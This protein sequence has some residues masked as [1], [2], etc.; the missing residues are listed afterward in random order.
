MAEKHSLSPEEYL[1]EKGGYSKE[2]SS[3][4]A[5]VANPEDP[6]A[7]SK[8]VSSKKQS[9]SDLFTI[10]CAGAALISDGYQN[11]LM[12]MVRLMSGRSTVISDPSCPNPF[13]R[14]LT[15]L[16]VWLFRRT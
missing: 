12:T 6:V 8:E 5:D 16:L 9:L 15:L 1:S 2:E 11:S 10:F 13:R 3:A 4:K 7:P 14:I